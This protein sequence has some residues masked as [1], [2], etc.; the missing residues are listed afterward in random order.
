M[1]TFIDLLRTRKS[2]RSYLQESVEGEKIERLIEA[3]LRAPSSMNRKPWEFVVV[4]D[5]RLL[6]NLSRS[7]PHGSSF[8]KGAALAIVVCADPRKSDI[9]MEDC[10]IASTFIQMA[11]HDEQLGSCWVQI[12]ERMHDDSISA[13]SYVRKTLDIPENY[14][15]ESIIALGYPQEAIFPARKEELPLG[16]VFLNSHGKPYCR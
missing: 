4:T 6:E 7:K 13:E 9:W 3:A 2:T 14:R 16:K 12:R 1:E 10:S 15:V 5:P 8:L 11:A